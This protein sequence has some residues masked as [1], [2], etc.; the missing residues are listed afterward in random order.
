[1]NSEKNFPYLFAGF[2]RSMRGP[3]RVMLSTAG[4]RQNALIEGPGSLDSL[5]GCGAAPRRG[6]A[7]AL[8]VM[9]LLTMFAATATAADKPNVI[10][11][12]TDDHG[13]ADLSCQGGMGILPT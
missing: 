12:F 11:V 7:V 5:A 10:V 4:R 6:V 2:V 13:Y 9:A 8:C 1:M 3:L